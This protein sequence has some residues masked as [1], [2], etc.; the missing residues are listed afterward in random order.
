MQ[1]IQL[2]QWV[3]LKVTNI[4]TLTNIFVT[5]LPLV[6]IANIHISTI[7]QK[8]STFKEVS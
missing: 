6:Y 5:L 7:L 3:I 2:Y 1:K 4:C 8:F